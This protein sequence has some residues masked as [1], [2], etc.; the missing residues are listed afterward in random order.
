MRKL[1]LV[2]FIVALFWIICGS[3]YA[4]DFQ[5]IHSPLAETEI[6]GFVKRIN[7]EINPSYSISRLAAFALN[8]WTVAIA[9]EDPLE[10]QNTFI[11]NDTTCVILSNMWLTEDGVGSPVLEMLFKD[12]RPMILR[13]EDDFTLTEV[14]LLSDEVGVSFLHV[15]NPLSPFDNVDIYLILLR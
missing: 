11:Y 13:N 7:P 1:S 12:T 2:L 9:T 10:Y 15:K 3:L 14:I 4:Q 5:R 6:Y 8:E